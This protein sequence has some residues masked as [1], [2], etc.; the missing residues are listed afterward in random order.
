MSDDGNDAS[1]LGTAEHQVASECLESGGD[2]W[3]YLGRVYCF[4][5]NRREAWQ[6]DVTNAFEVLHAVELDDEAIQRVE[7]YVNFVRDLVR[8]T[9]GVLLVEKRVP[10]DHI[11][12]EPGAGGTADTI[13]I[14]GDELIIADYKSGQIRVDAYEVV[15]GEMLDPITGEI[16]PPIT[17]PNSQLAMYAHGALRDYGWM[18]PIKRVRYIIVQPRHNATP[19]YSM[20]VEELEAFIAYVRVK[21]EETRTNP[22]FVPSIDNCQFCKA[23]MTCEA[24]QNLVLE[25]T[26]DGFQP[27][28]VESLIAA[29]PKT[30]A[31]NWLGAAYDKLDIIQQW[32]KDIHA[33]VYNALLAGDPVVNS[34]GD[35]LKLVEGRAG[36]RYW[37]DESAVR[38]ALSAHGVP[39][40]R[41]YKPREVISPAEAEKLAKAKRGKKG[42]PGTPA[43]LSPKQWDELQALIGQ[44]DGKPSIAPATDPRPAISPRTAGF[45]DS[46]APVEDL[47][48]FS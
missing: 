37:K 39:E 23:R 13:I 29:K 11:T 20:T 43:L 6:E 35:A 4:L 9:G 18:A 42:A 45:T 44:D 25:T 12:G 10:I 46:Q 14:A 41:A 40:D 28:D 27:G 22:Q 1:R 26:L 16:M 36:N 30:V 5:P 48:L 19:E 2:C 38:D 8:L 3:L 21:A 7:Q 32:C 31:A 15:R 33:R 34:K 17:E 47:D 24:R